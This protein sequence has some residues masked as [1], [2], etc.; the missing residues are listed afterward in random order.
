VNQMLLWA[1]T[2]QCDGERVGVA[3]SQAA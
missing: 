2:I 1:K 3:R